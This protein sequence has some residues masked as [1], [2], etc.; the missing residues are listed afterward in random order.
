MRRALACR[1]SRCALL[2]AGCG[3]SDKPTDK[4][5]IETM[6]KTYYK[7]FGTGDSGGACDE[8]AKGTTEELE[9]AA[10]ART[11]PRSL[12]QALKRP[13]YAKVA[14]KLADVKVSEVTIAGDKATA[15]TD[16]A[17][18]GQADGRAAEEG[19]RRPGRSRAP[20]VSRALAVLR[21][22]VVVAAGRLRRRRRAE[23][24]SPPA[25]SDAVTSFT[26]AFAAGDGAAGVRPAHDR[27]RRR[28]SS[29][30]PQVATGA[31]DCPS[32]LKR[33]HDL[34]GSSVTGPLAARDRERREGHGRDRHRD[35]HGRRALDDREP[36]E[37]GRRLEAER[38]AGGLASPGSV[39]SVRTYVI[40]YSD[41]RDG[42]RNHHT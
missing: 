17:R 24:P 23:V 21:V 35:A 40:T 28:R 7:A 32:S 31:K 15:K 10:A 22:V 5:Q 27:L 33:V 26:K 11:A 16:R 1:D 12:D 3:A 6:L 13:D 19:S 4:E 9:K 41:H 30:A 18:R 8:L 42:H 39:D 20:S 34:A 37:A 14:P 36:L 29:S 38:G 2:V 25:A